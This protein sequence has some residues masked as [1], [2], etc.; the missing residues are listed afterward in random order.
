MSSDGKYTHDQIKPSFK[1]VEN[2]GMLRGALTR[3]DTSIRGE[4]KDLASGVAP[5]PIPSGLRHTAAPLTT[6]QA[7]LA[8]VLADTIMGH[9]TQNF[10]WTNRVASCFFWVLNQLKRA[11]QLFEFAHISSRPHH[12]ARFYYTR[13]VPM[14]T[15]CTVPSITS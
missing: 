11:N 10:A 12:C 9:P 1:A 3:H 8:P 2:S 6:L 14:P 15:P 5:D 7:S 4:K 13:V